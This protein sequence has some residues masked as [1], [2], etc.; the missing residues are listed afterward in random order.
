[1]HFQRQSEIEGYQFAEIPSLVQETELLNAVLFI[2]TS[3]SYKPFYT[4]IS[5]N[6]PFKL[7][8]AQTSYPCYFMTIANH[9]AQV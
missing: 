8:K 7:K 4:N 3:I 5:S 9:K 6:N 2:V 1:M